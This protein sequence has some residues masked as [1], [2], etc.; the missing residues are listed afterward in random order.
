MATFWRFG[1]HT[2]LSAAICC[3]AISPA[4]AQQLD[5]DLLKRLQSQSGSSSTVQDS[6][7]DRARDRSARDQ[8]NNGTAS[9]PLSDDLKDQLDAARLRRQLARIAPPTPVEKDFR[10]RTNNPA[11]QQFGYD[12]FGTS[13]PATSQP[14]TGDVG[15]AYVLGVGDEMVVTFQGS[16]SRTV[17]TRVDREGRLV[18]DQLRPIVAAGRSLGSVRRDVEAATRATL[19]GT[20]VYMSIG[21]VRAVT[22]LVGGE[23]NRAGSFTVTSLTDVASILARAGG[24][25]PSGSLRRIR[26]VRGGQSL[27]YDLYGLLGIGTPP[28]MRLRDGDRVVV[29]AIGQVIALSGGVARPG[30][31]ELPTGGSVS[32]GQALAMAGGPLRPRGND[33]VVSRIGRNGD[34]QYI[35]L[36]NQNARLQAGDAVIVNARVRAA[37]GRMTLAGY[38]DSP[39]VRSIGAAPSIAA[40]I[41]GADNLKQGSYLPMAVLVRSDSVTRARQYRAVNLVNILTKGQDVPLRSDDTLYVF[42]DTD[43]A[44]LQSDAVRR[45][46]LGAPYEEKCEALTDLQNIIRDADS[47]RF[48]AVIRGTFIVDRNGKAEVAGGLGAQTQLGI[49]D[50]DAFSETNEK[51]LKRSEQNRSLREER[52]LTNDQKMQAQQRPADAQ[53]EFDDMQDESLLSPEKLKRKRLGCPAVF[54]EDPSLMTFLLEHSVSISGAVRRPGAY[55]MAGQ[56]DLSTVVAVTQGM[57]LD[58]LRNSVEVTR[59][60]DSTVQP[61]ATLLSLADRRLSDVALLAGDDIRFL[62]QPQTQEA[63]AILL[64]GE[65]VRPGLYS[66]SKGEKISSVIAR[67]GGVSTSAYPYGAVFTRRSVK[68]AQQEGFKRTSREISAS[69]L[70]LSARRNV[71]ADAI[72]A[73][74]ELATSIATVEAP[75]RVVIE[76]DP[77]VLE[78]RADLDIQVEAG[79]AI[80][81]PKLPNF[82]LS[83]GDLLN[84]SALQFIPNKSVTAYLREAGGFQ[85]SADKKRVFIVYPNGI[86][87][88]VR[89][90]SWRSSQPTLPPGSTIVVPKNIDPLAKLDLFKDVAQIIG[91]LAVS[92]A[93]IAVISKN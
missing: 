84:P 77:R 75:G 87:Q 90:S 71:S 68:A 59:Y 52:E 91:Q 3:S 7:I 63:G 14:V 66:I 81:M 1:R 74:Q 64:S 6:A 26:V 83:I 27:T 13:Q 11:L 85:I 54:G 73:A 86:A 58:A 2:L 55:P 46:L 70:T 37:E 92:F 25:R 21:A 28:N 15:D 41:G 60:S 30:I 33:F 18:V 20:D 69:I 10:E 42:A 40:L 44:F 53:K 35:T 79:D 19:L 51:Q 17:T 82:V 23:V 49:R 5:A 67:A 76:A 12:L 39:G 8:Q 45:I 32:I 56:V 93:S 89:M 22:V 47:Q 62:S 34:E 43:I 50:P 31:Y 29:P 36:S 48:A 4:M 24:I 61:R 16:T 80:Y 88:P 57:T 65:F 9:G 38:V 72:V 78:R